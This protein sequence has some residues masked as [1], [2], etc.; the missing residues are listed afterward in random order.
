MYNFQMKWNWSFKWK[1][2]FNKYDTLISLINKIFWICQ[3]N[4]VVNY[5]NRNIK[6]LFNTLKA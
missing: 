4:I 1:S 2:Y 5:A 6:Y 3:P